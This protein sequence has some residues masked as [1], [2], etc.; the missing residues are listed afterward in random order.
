[1]SGRSPLFRLPAVKSH[2]YRT[3]DRAKIPAGEYMRKRARKF[4]SF[5]ELDLTGI[6]GIVA[7]SIRFLS[8]ALEGHH[9]QRG[10]EHH[11]HIIDVRDQEYDD[12]ERR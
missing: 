3:D 10:I 2:T 11:N 7:S 5:L 9:R 6:A 4:F 1:M 12:D 8:A